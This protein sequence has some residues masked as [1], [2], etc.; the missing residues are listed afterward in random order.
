MPGEAMIVNDCLE[1][2]F[3]PHYN[4][5]DEHFSNT[6][7]DVFA[8]SRNVKRAAIRG[9]SNGAAST[10]DCGAIRRGFFDRLPTSV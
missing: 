9:E 4:Y 6:L 7:A 2:V 3:A 1:F 8:D 5:P 10:Y